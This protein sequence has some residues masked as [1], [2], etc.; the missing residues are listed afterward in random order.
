MKKNLI[1]YLI[2]AIF[3][4]VNSIAYAQL[5]TDVYW[6]DLSVGATGQDVK[7]L[8]ILLN[9]D[10]ET[11]VSESGAGS[12]GNE[13]EYFGSKT[14]DAVI[15]FQD[16]YYE[17]VLK[18][19]N[20]SHGTGYVGASTRRKLNN[21][22][23]SITSYSK[24]IVQENNSASVQQSDPQ[25]LENTN[26]VNETNYK[27]NTWQTEYSQI[28][29]DKETFFESIK[30]IGSLQGMEESELAKIDSLVREEAKKQG[31]GKNFVPEVL[32]SGGKI[33]ET[34]ANPFSLRGFFG[35]LFS[36]V[37]PNSAQAI[38]GTPFGGRVL[39]P[40]LCT[41]SGNWLITITPHAPS[42]VVLLTYY[43][44]TQIYM[45]YNIPFTLAMVGEYTQ[46]SQCAIYAGVTCVSV[47]S[48]GQIGSG[49][50][51]SQL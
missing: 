1:Y 8:Q 19:V 11:L 25:K 27:N 17:E 37:T 9:N 7:E 34:Q 21:L 4:L 10:P 28:Q 49:T 12:L 24:P 14:K 39:F 18:T 16:K 23:N 40:F 44:G 3:L 35:K 41:C 47:P 15:R 36:L 33:Y 43:T 50:G 22:V 20:L 2:P 51:S 5:G 6:R 38:S 30:K 26:T 45:G 29:Y 13:T 31:Y 32:G 46:G 48:Q 42:Y